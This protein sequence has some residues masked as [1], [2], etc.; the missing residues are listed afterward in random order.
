VG[1]TYTKLPIDLLELDEYREEGVARDALPACDLVSA[2][3]HAT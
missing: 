3:H 2:F 1:S